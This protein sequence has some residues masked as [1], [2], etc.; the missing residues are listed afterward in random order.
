MPKLG[1]Y[2]ISQ[3]AVSTPFEAN[4]TPI[5]DGSAGPSGIVST[6][7]Q[8][9]IEE[10]KSSAST[11]ANASRGAVSCGFDGS[12]S[13]GRYLEFFSNNPSNGSP[14]VIPEPG[15]IRAISASASSS[16]TGVVTLYKNAVSVATLTFTAAQSARDKT[17][18]ISVTDLDK[19]S[20]GV[21][22]GTITRPTFFIFVQTL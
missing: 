16:S 7:T 20:V 4:R 14:Y 12:A 13:S 1:A 19:L 10:V 5:W 3:V 21:T 17:L 8:S 2:Q 15:I 9:A 18:N 22:S 6:D 11:A